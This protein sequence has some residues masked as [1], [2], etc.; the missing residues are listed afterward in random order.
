MRRAG[1]TDVARL[2]E[3]LARI[4][5]RIA[6]TALRPRLAARGA[7]AARD[8]PRGRDGRGDRGNPPPRIRS[9][10]RSRARLARR[11]RLKPA[12]ERQYRHGSRPGRRGAA[13]VARARPDPLADRAL[14]AAV[15]APKRWP[16]V[17]GTG[18][19]RLDLDTRVMSR[20]VSYGVLI[21]Y[22]YDIDGGSA[23]AASASA[24]RGRN[25]VSFEGRAKRRL[26]SPRWRARDRLLRS[27]EAR[28]WRDLAE[29]AFIFVLRVIFWFFLV[30]A[31]WLIG[32][33]CWCW[34][35][36]FGPEPL[37]RL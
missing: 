22:E 30:L 14:A 18:R 2:A 7:G 11:A 25:F 33:P 21:A 27:G 32:A 16:T 4:K 6:H 12:H 17:P 8:R 28:R 1:L 23:I 36:V 19:R 24:Y 29:R 20:G 31:V 26:A 35:P 10:G 3:M 37:I 13:G 9:R 15:D 34:S 5:G